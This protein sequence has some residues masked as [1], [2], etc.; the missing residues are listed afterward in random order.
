MKKGKDSST[1]G[2]VNRARDTEV[3]CIYGSKN[4]G[5]KRRVGGEREVQESHRGCIR[6]RPRGE[7]NQEKRSGGVERRFRSGGGNRNMV[8]SWY[9]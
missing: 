9:K 3:M 1:Q 2:G 4:G 8:C 7:N 6:R 5:R